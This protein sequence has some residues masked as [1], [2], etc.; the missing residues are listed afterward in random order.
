MV[1]IAGVPSWEFHCRGGVSNPLSRALFVR[2]VCGLPTTESP[3]LPPRLV[4]E[5]TEAS[6]QLS[7][8]ERLAAGMAWERWWEG[9]VDLNVRL[10]GGYALP[11]PSRWRRDA[12][13]PAAPIGCGPDYEDLADRPA[14]RKAVLVALA[15]WPEWTAQ[16]TRA[17]SDGLNEPHWPQVTMAAE[18]VIADHQIP[19]HL[20][21][22]LVFT[23]PM[24]GSWWSRWSPGVV[25]CAESAPADPAVEREILR[26]AYVSSFSWAA[27]HRSV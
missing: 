26:D 9:T 23:L 12:A 3:A 11:R 18:A 8:S 21:R 20:V 4:E 22:A 24:A 15:Y 19:A 17:C 14:L 13:L 27:S 16:R 25:L 1:Q 10:S 7:S 5:R 2:D 6:G